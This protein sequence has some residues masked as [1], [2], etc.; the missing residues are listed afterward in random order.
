MMDKVET[1]K[2]LPLG[3]RE[4]PKKRVDTRG[5]RIT[6][7]FLKVLVYRRAQDR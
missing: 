3:S 1:M 7:D 2:S 6:T 4:G 5:K